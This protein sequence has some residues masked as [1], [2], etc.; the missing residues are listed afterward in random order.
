MGYDRTRRLAA[1]TGAVNPLEPGIYMPLSDTDIERYRPVKVIL[2]HI[3]KITDT[4]KIHYPGSPTPLDINETGKRRYIHFDT[5]KMEVK[6][7]GSE[8]LVIYQ[9]EEI[10][11]F[12]ADDMKRYIKNRPIS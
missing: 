9:S 12:P 7:V 8:S 2:G 6:S 11:L 5:D 3:H 10:V 1:A 4:E